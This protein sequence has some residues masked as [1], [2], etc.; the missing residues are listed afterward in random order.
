MSKRLL[1]LVILLGPLGISLIPG[2]GIIS[3]NLQAEEQ[4]ETLSLA[5]QDVVSGPISET[6]LSAQNSLVNDSS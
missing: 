1:S 5:A 2:L 3:A 4:T 6:T